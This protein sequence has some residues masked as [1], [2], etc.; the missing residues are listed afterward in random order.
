MNNNTQNMS[1]AEFR[2]RIKTQIHG[3]G[4]IRPANPFVTRKPTDRG[5][6]PPKAAWI[7]TPS[8]CYL[9]G[10]VEGLR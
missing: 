4:Y 6:S 9:V 7:E 8:A 5:Y 3:P 10:E 1:N 2:E